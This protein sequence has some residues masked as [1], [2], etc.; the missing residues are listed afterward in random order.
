MLIEE[1]EKKEKKE[2]RK[3]LLMVAVRY[4]G[5]VVQLPI[6]EELRGLNASQFLQV[7]GS[8]AGNAKD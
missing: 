6:S 8:S 1:K 2:D 7:F 3:S 5:Q 4:R